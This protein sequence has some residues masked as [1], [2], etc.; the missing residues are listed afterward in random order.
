MRLVG[1]RRKLLN[2]IA[3]LVGSTPSAPRSRSRDPRLHYRPHANPRRTPSDHGDVLRSRRL[4]EPRRE[5][6][7]RGLAQP[8]QRLSRRSV[9][10][11]DRFWRPCAEEARRRADGALRL[12]AGAGERRRARRARGARHPARARRPQRQERREG[13]AGAFRPHRPR[14]RLGRGRRRPARCS[15]TRRTSRRACKLLPSQGRSW[16]REACSARWP[17]SSSSRRRARTS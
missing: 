13:R 8:R 15:A 11:G 9:K 5:A 6:R 1:D 2:A 17:G 3:A 12:S 7:R 14:V 16:S 10:G 4:D